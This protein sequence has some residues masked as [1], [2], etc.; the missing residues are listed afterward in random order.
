MK[1]TVVGFVNKFRKRA[2]WYRPPPFTAFYVANSCNTT[3][4]TQKMYNSPSK[5]NYSSNH[6]TCTKSEKEESTGLF[7]L[8][9]GTPRNQI[10]II[11]CARQ[12]VVKMN[13]S[14]NF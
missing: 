14:E 4:I 3:V 5:T 7:G 11:K 2:K 9:E 8:K 13:C 6:C 12:A 10:K 1:N